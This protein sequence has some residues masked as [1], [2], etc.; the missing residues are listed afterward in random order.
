MSLPCLPRFEA[1]VSALTY[2]L[3]DAGGVTDAAAGRFIQNRVCRYILAEHGRLPDYLRLPMRMLTLL[4]DAQTLPFAG[5]AFHALP[6]ERRAPWIDR[7]RTAPLGACRDFIRFH[8]SLAIFA[9][10]DALFPPPPPEP[11]R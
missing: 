9:G 1:A 7:W 8:E 6:P 2:S 3:L 5:V 10:Y 11:P 4:F